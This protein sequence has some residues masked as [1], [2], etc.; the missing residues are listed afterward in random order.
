MPVDNS[1]VLYYLYTHNI[2]IMYLYI[3]FARATVFTLLRLL[4]I[5]YRC[6]DNII[7]CLFES[8]S[9]VDIRPD[10]CYDR[11]SS[12]IINNDMFINIACANPLD[13]IHADHILLN[14]PARQP[15]SHNRD[16]INHFRGRY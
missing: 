2:N 6:I 12:T 16:D 11:S 3:L 13:V 1:A 10:V 15:A 7:L 4:T 5:L 14:I 8:Y 9:T